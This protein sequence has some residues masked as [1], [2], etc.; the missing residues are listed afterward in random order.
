MAFC[1]CSFTSIII[2]NSVTIISDCVFFYCPYLISITIPNSVATIGNMA[3]TG[4]SSL[5]S[6]N[7]ES[8]N[9]NY[10][11]EDGVLFN[12]NKTTLICCPEMKTGASYAIPSSVTTIAKA[13]FNGCQNLTTITIPNSVE[14]IEDIAFLGS[15]NLA[16][17]TVPSSVTAIGWNAFSFCSSLTSIDVESENNN[18]SSENGVLFDKSKIILIR[19]PGGKTGEFVIPN[20][21]ASIEEA[22]FSSCENL[23]SITIPNGVTTIGYEA[24]C[25][26]SGL[27]S[28][29]I[30]NSVTTIGNRAF[31]LCSALTSVTNLNPVPIEISSDVFG[32]VNQNECTLEVPLTSVS[33]FQNAEVWKEFNIVGIEVGIET[34]ETPTIKI[35]PN[36]TS[37]ELRI[38]S[39][40]S[41]IENVVIY[42]VFGKIQRID[43][44]KTE[45]IIDISHLPAGVYFVKIST[46]AGEVTRKVLKE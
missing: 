34:V 28:V 17:I 27:N 19:Y 41:K 15:S 43:N 12:K 44:W 40:E 38:E 46:E 35:Y 4:C 24:F 39:G 25:Y 3:F 45:N 13:A 20:S 8:E 6:I 26:C 18:Y 33:T 36:P 16:S 23:T 11:S 2:P 22:A 5:T 7:V 29:T 37:R 32:Y 9:N 10:T 1:Y 21:V 14:I 31:F 30:S 42:D